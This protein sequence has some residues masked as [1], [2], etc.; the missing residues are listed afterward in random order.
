MIRV[1]RPRSY[2]DYLAFPILGPVLDDF[3]QWSKQHG[4]RLGT[5]SNQ[6]N[7]T[8][9]I[10]AFFQSQGL[11]SINELTHCD[12][13]KGWQHFRQDHPS[14][15]GTIRQM[16]QF[17]DETHGLPPPP[18]ITQTRLRNELERFS[19]YMKNVRGLSDNTIR[20]HIIY[21]GP[22][23][24]SIGF[25]T[26]ETALST[27][28]L[29]H[30][31]DFIV[32]CSKDLNRYSLQHVV[33]YLRA[34]LRFE[35]TRGVLQTPLHEMIDTP[36]VYRLEKLPRT[37]PWSVVNKLL[38]SIDRTDEQGIRNYAMLLLIATYGMRSCEVVS[39][40]LDDINWRAATIRISQ[41]KN[42]NH[43]VLPLTD[44]VGNALID[45]LRNG[46]PNLPYRE[47][48]LR[49]RA[50]HGRLKPTAVAEVFQRQVHLSGI[51]IPYHG[52]HC[53]R[54]SYAVHLLRQ[55]TSVKVIGDV[56]GHRNIESTCVYL[57]LAIDDLRNVALDIPDNP[58]VDIHVDT[59]ALKDLPAA[60]SWRKVKSSMPL[61]SFLAEEITAYLQLHRSLGKIYRREKDI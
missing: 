24:N 34:F 21:L 25:E 26:N 39:L 22:F 55:G 60:R 5:I 47:V 28:S 48:F 20:S 17:L 3:T 30:V 10:I 12:F 54:H 6:L 50:P 46:R 7:D 23:L 53:L 19:G 11:Q 32:T 43:L 15:A 35:Y 36:R 37:L 27:L 59:T 4:Y 40:S 8:R 42:D 45:Y 61:Q 56:L 51:D 44:A 31:E 33:G 16:Q 1:I 41:G 18:A 57:R 49:I 13:E 38:N 2:K 14:T 9:H 29:K 52:A 58:G